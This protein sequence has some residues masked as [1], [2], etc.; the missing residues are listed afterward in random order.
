MALSKTKSRPTTLADVARASGFSVSTVSIVLNKAPLSQHIKPTTKESVLK[1]AQKL[2]YRPDASARSLR[3]RSTQTIGVLIFDISDPFCTLIL[4]GIQKSLYPTKYLPIIM[5]ANND[6]NQLAAYVDLLM[7]RRV[8]GLIVV[9]NWLF[10]AAGLLALLQGTKLPTI[11]VGRDL[12][13]E[14]IRSAVV[15][16]E[17]GGYLAI[18]H[19]YELGH[20]KIAVVRGP[21]K[22]AD[23]LR[24]WIG[25]KRFA[26]EHGLRLDPKLM[27][28]LPGGVA[29]NCE[30]KR[31]QV[32]TEELIRSG[33]RFTALIAFDDL[34]ALGCIRALSHA[35]LHVPQ[36]CSVI[37][38]DD[39]PQASLTTP[40]LTSISQPM[41]AM[42][43]LAGSWV[44]AELTTSAGQVNLP[45]ILHV[46]PPTLVVRESTRILAPKR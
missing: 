9:A 23:S 15:D 40:D 35:G 16:N 6:R 26:A 8:E 46:F 3:K 38:F 14:S 5:D 7:E 1:A 27:R 2:R 10:E 29:A 17:R 20:R 13:K 32:E 41:Q 33:A 19:L 28:Q 42:G 30:F 36:D 45:P 44:S 21:Q 12:S 18:Q 31:G 22:L 34:T 43:E 24:R 4:R 37:G 39:V 11:V 25:I